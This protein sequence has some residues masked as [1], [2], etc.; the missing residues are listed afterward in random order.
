MNQLRDNTSRAK[1]IIS[2]FWIMLGIT[3]VN[4]GSLA[5]QYT[6][7]VDI[8]A[9]P[10]N[11]N[12]QTANISDTLQA[13]LSIADLGIYILAVVFFIKWFR[14]AYYNLHQLK[15]HNARYTEGW[16]AGSWFVP[17]IWWWWPYQ[18]MM[19]IWKGTQ[20]AV[21]ERLGEPQSA[22]IV[23][24]WWAIYLISGFYGDFSARLS[25]KAEEL[26]EL[27]VSTKVDF[28]GEILSLPAIIITII[29]IQRTSN[30]EKELL[31]HSETP[32]DSIFSDNY[33]PSTEN[34]EPK[35]EL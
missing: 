12:E 18:I 9:D 30:F 10:D 24:W 5:W 27:L 28:I 13:V 6:L 35:I 21:R 32:N 29:L 20:S 14:R 23:G 11:Y 22:A 33:T 4:I 8:Q 26:D 19:D 17:I 25:W 15:W 34:I 2:I 3:I 31:V 1:Q 16:A 7:L